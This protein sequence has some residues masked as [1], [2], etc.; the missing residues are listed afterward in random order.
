[1]SLWPVEDRAAREWMQALYRARLE[2]R[3]S[4]A[5]AVRQASQT[6]LAARRAARRSTHPLFWAGFVAAGDWR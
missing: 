1:M 5:E 4:T 3:L 2:D 6:V